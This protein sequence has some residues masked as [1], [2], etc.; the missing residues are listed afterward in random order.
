MIVGGEPAIE[1]AGTIAL[2]REQQPE[3][4]ELA[5]VQLRLGVLGHVAQHR[6]D[7]H[8]QTNDNI[9]RRHANLP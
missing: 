8:V 9:V 6:V 3:G 2:E 5:W 4:D 1:A 7:A